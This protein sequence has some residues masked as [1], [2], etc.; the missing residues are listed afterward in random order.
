MLKYFGSKK[1]A[2]QLRSLV[3]KSLK[4]SPFHRN[5]LR[6]VSH[7]LAANRD[8]L[9]LVEAMG[10]DNVTM[11]CD[12]AIPASY[13]ADGP[14]N[15][16]HSRGG[17]K[18]LWV[19]RMLTRKALPLALDALKQVRK[20][21]TLT[22]AGDGMDPRIVCEVIAARKLQGRVFWKGQRLTF[23]ELRSAYAEH[24]AMLFTSLRDSFGSQLL[25]ALAMGLP[26]I[27]LDLH[28]ARD[29]VPAAASI[30]VPV[31][32]PSETVRNLANGVEMYASYSSARKN[33]MSQHAWAFA[34]T[35]TWPAR[36]EM[37]EKLYEEVVAR[38]SPLKQ[39]AYSPA[40]TTIAKG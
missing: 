18:L 36:A 3:T 9:H 33:E 37:I 31:G 14:R 28:G 1:S 21:V 40:V 29:H 2:E 13:F 20:D 15:F 38:R 23:E 27:T 24:D 8:T 5:C 34:K 11:M 26:V 39:V 6:R 12:T 32:T 7:I 22:I 30:K 4:S 25:E 35:L 19:G 16:E 10:C 17:V